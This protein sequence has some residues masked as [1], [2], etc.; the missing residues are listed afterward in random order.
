MTVPVEADVVSVLRLR[1]RCADALGIDVVEAGAGWAVVSMTV[2]GDMCN[3]HGTCHGGIIFTLA[4]TAFG[5][6]CNSH[7]VN[8]VASAASVEFLHPVPEGATIRA[9]AEQRWARSKSG[10]YD[11]VVELDDGTAVALFRGRSHSIGGS[12]VP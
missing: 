9:R 1:D 11:V 2:R 12:V 7:N 4:D 3:C 8:T 5:Y 6:A 10:V